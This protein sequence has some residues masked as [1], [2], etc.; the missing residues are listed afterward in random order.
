MKGVGIHP[1]CSKAA[2]LFVHPWRWKEEL[3]LEWFSLFPERPARV[4]WVLL[5]TP[6]AN[7]EE[8]PGAGGQVPGSAS[9]S[10]GT[11]RLCRSLTPT[12]SSLQARP[13]SSTC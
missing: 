9:R 5:P 2:S 1:L 4:E 11:A 12:G 3:G 6:P 13:G 7:A 10:Q 8:D